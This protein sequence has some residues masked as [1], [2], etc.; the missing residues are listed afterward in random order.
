MNTNLGFL[1]KVLLLSALGA[2]LIKFLGPLLSISGSNAIALTI[3]LSPTL[4]L[5]ILLSWRASHQSSDS[6]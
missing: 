4:I 2:V 3:V 6:P 1:L 5:G